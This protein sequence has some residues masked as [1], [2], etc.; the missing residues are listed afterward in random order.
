VLVAVVTP[1]GVAIVLVAVMVVASIV[2]VVVTGKPVIVPMPV[3]VVMG[4]VPRLVFVVVTTVGVAIV[5][6]MPFVAMVVVGE[7]VVSVPVAVV[8]AMPPGLDNQIEGGRGLADIARDIGLP[9]RQGVHTVRERVR[10]GYRPA[11]VRTHCRRSDRVAAVKQRHNVPNFAGP[12]NGR[13]R[14]VCDVLAIEVNLPRGRHSQ[15]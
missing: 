2:V 5:V 7:V 3:M 1:I 15:N 4:V 14:R 11:A 6:T 9:R 12:G 8:M 10:Q 13:P